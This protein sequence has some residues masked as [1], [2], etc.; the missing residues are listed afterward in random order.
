MTRL[1]DELARLL[2]QEAAL[3]LILD[4]TS[5]SDQVQPIA[6]VLLVVQARIVYLRNELEDE[7]VE[8][9]HHSLG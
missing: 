1:H 2:R 5:E 6:A 8:L 7:A 3:K 4:E 9:A